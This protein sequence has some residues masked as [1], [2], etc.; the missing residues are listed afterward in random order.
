MGSGSV[1]ELERGGGTG[2][3]G[4]DG[5]SNVYYESSWLVVGLQN[6]VGVCVRDTVVWVFE[7]EVGGAKA[8]GVIFV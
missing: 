1:P 5:R 4:A 8:A 2:A 3:E 7:I 6:Q